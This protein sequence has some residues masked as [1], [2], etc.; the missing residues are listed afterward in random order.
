MMMT[1]VDHSVSAPLGM[2]SLTDIRV[3]SFPNELLFPKGTGSG[4]AFGGKL[5]I[6]PEQNRMQNVLRTGRKRDKCV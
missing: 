2:A 3:K 1:M 4:N 5:L 6:L